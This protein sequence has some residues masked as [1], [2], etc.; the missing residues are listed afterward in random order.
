HAPV[1]EVVRR[2]WLTSAPAALGLNEYAGAS[3]L[4]EGV[5]QLRPHS[6]DR[7]AEHECGVGRPRD[8]ARP[9]PVDV[10]STGIEM[11]RTDSPLPAWCA[12]RA[13]VCCEQNYAGQSTAKS[14]P[15]TGRS[16]RGDQLAAQ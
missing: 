4:L 9:H 6:F 15:C 1:R 12:E 10:P 3:A 5:L 2:D 11:N 14:M 8:Q 7:L 16:C 13:Y